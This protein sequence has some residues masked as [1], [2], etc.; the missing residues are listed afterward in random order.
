MNQKIEY[1]KI[2]K[3][4]QEKFENLCTENITLKNLLEMKKLL[5][6]EMIFRKKE[7][8]RRNEEE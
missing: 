1:V 8:N 4:A 3:E 5:N 7:M 6:I 2:Y